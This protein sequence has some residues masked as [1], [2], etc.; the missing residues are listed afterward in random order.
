MTQLLSRAARVRAAI[1]GLAAVGVVATLPSEANQGD[2]W[3]FMVAARHHDEDGDEA[4]IVVVWIGED[5]EW[6]D[7]LLD[8]SRWGGVLI[9]ADGAADLL[10]HFRFPGALLKEAAAAEAAALREAVDDGLA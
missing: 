2:I 3:D 6:D 7:A 1:A 8:Q 5:A 10:S 9:V 4:E